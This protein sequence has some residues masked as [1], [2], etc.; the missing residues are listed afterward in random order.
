MKLNKLACSVVGIL[1]SVSQFASAADIST[2][3]PAV[4]GVQVVSWQGPYAGLVLGY[5]SKDE[6]TSITG[7]NSFSNYLIAKS[8][9]PSSVNVRPAGLTIGLVGGYDFQFGKVV[10]GIVGDWS[11]ADAYGTGTA[12]SNLVNRTVDEKISSFGTIRGRLGY[13]VGP[14]GQERALVYVTGGGA[15]ANIKSTITSSGSVCGGSINC[16]S[17]TGSDTKFGWVFGGGAEYRINSNLSASLEALY[18][19]LGTYDTTITGSVYKSPVSY[20]LHQD[21]NIGTIRTALTYRF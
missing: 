14:N 11:Y 10:A 18:A 7:N 9:V 20:T 8:L 6:S 16:A 3:A 21:V 13:L 17:G 15:W 2:K 1:L 12:L 4:A 19:K 5:L